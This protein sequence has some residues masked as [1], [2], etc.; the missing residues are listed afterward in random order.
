M[1]V[2]DLLFHTERGQKISAAILGLALGLT[3]LFSVRREKNKGYI[4]K[5]YESAGGS[6]GVG[7][8]EHADYA[9]IEH[10]RGSDSD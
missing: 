4:N 10:R 6:G 2:A 5:K 8:Y 7:A 3:I 9:I 1:Y